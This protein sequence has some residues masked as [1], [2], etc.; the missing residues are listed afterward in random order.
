MTGELFSM[1]T[2]THRHRNTEKHTHTLSDLALI[3]T[4]Y[5]LHRLFSTYLWCSWAEL[6]LPTK[7]DVLILNSP[8]TSECDL[9]WRPNLLFFFAF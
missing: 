3:I 4:C 8:S 2:Q 9:I 6:G 7:K 5:D 1:P